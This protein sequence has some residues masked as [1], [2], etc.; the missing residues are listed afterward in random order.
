MSSHDPPI[1]FDTV[2]L[3]YFALVG[4]LDLLVDLS[5][6]SLMTTSVIFD[7]DETAGAAHEPPDEAALCEISGCLNYYRKRGLDPRL[8]QAERDAAITAVA[9]LGRIAE[10]Y[11][12]DRLEVIELS[13]AEMDVYVSLTSADSAR[14]LGLRRSIDFGEASCIAAAVAR[15][16]VLASD[17]NDALA[18]LRA[19]DPARPIERIRKLLVRAVSEERI[20]PAQADAIH[21]DMRQWGF[22]DTEFR[23]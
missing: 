8:P 14:G 20:T 5:A 21:R 12:S 16:L 18:A 10:L 6:G 22:R 9:R 13:A 19:L 1:V 11:A 23:F 15:D 7:P 17:D 4:E 3:L 2:V